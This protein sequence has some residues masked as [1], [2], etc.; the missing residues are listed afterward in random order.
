MNTLYHFDFGCAKY[1]ELEKILSD[2]RVIFLPTFESS[3][4]VAKSGNKET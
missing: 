2:Y 1:K 4:M 3:Q